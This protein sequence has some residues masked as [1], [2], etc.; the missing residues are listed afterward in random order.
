VTG[1]GTLRL[2]MLEARWIA[3]EQ[4]GAAW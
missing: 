3:V 1:T 4:L 2:T